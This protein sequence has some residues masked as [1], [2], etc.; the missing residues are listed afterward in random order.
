MVLGCIK[1][2]SISFNK[3]KIFFIL[4]TIFSKKIFVIIILGSLFLFLMCCIFYFMGFNYIY[5]SKIHIILTILTLYSLSNPLIKLVLLYFNFL[6]KK[7]YNI[8]FSLNCLQVFFSI[9]IC[10][11]I[12]SELIP[13]VNKLHLHLISY[14]YNIFKF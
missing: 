5:D 6:Q 12:Q 14:D 2:D 9:I 11:F 3:N 13:L 7:D 10:N 4:S 1:G 8:Y